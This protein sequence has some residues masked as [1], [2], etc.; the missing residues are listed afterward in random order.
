M[1]RPTFKK[2]FTTIISPTIERST[3]ILLSSL[4]LLLIY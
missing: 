1:A 3:Y 4:G 2:W